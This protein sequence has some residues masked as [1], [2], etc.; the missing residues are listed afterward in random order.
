MSLRHELTIIAKSSPLL[1]EAAWWFRKPLSAIG[2]LAPHHI[3]RRVVTR[4]CEVLIDGYPRSANTFACDAFTV[5]QGHSIK[6]RSLNGYPIKLANHMHAPAQFVLAKKY[7]IPAMLVLR[8]PVAAA[9]SWRVFTHGKDAAN[10]WLRHN[11]GKY[12]AY[13]ALRDYIRF[14]EPL[15]AIRDHFVVAP[16][17]EVTKDFGKSIERL[18]EKFG[19]KFLVFEHTKDEEEKIFHNMKINTEKRAGKLGLDLTRTYH[20]PQE[21]KQEIRDGLAAEFATPDIAPL[22]NRAVSIYRE[23]MESR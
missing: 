5:A 20:F 3:I 18:N 1:L 4:D 8:E 14:H 21:R 7:V 11:Q 10:V 15:L 22:K 23:L 13:T 17:E 9:L 6:D 2:M 12:P 16:F 19:T